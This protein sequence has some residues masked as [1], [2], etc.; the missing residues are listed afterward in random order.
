MPDFPKRVSFTKAWH[1][2]PYPFISPTRAGLSA[3]GKNVVVTGGGTGI[4]LATAI[5]FAEAEAK[6]VSIVGRRL[7]KLQAGVESIKAVTE[8]T[9]TQ[10]LYQVADLSDAEQV[11]SAFKA[12]ADEVGNIDILVSNAG[13]LPPFG[14]IVGYNPDDLVRGFD[15]NVFSAFNSFQAFMPLAGPNPIILNISSCLANITPVPMVSAY[16]ITKAAALKM[17]EYLGAE[18]PHLRVVNIQPGWVPTDMNGHQSEAPDVGKFGAKYFL[19]YRP[20]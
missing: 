11:K 15:G 2:T 14:P 9:K 8:F 16:A 7:D 6:F 17:M 3:T 20:V 5:A 19:S 1:T 10:V 18:N 4:G 13:V 12:I